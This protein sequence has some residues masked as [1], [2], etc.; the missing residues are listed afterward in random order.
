MKTELLRAKSRK[1]HLEYLDT[2]KELEI[3]RCEQKRRSGVYRQKEKSFWSEVSSPSSKRAEKNSSVELRHSPE[4]LGRLYQLQSELK[5]AHRNNSVICSEM[6]QKLLNVQSSKRRLDVI[7]EVLTRAVLSRKRKACEVLTEE[8]EGLAL[9]AKLSGSKLVRKDS[10][11]VHSNQAAFEQSDVGDHLRKDTE[12]GP[13][14]AQ[15]TPVENNSTNSHIR[16]LGSAIGVVPS[17]V[18][19]DSTTKSIK[20]CGTEGHLKGVSIRVTK[21]QM[22]NIHVSVALPPICDMPGRPSVDK[23]TIESRLGHLGV[24]ISSLEFESGSSGADTSL[25]DYRR[26]KRHE[27][28]LYDEP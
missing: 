7:E 19:Q 10:V 28:E 5:D 4:L 18:T 9:S 1:S 27:G 23:L 12:L 25:L 6:Q 3:T 21:D 15:L 20:L 11:R 26:R 8:I 13:V 2:L 22:Q 16:K 17:V 24:R 14:Q